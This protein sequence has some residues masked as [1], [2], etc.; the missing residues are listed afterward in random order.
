MTSDHRQLQ[1]YPCRLGYPVRK[2]PLL[3]LVPVK[4]PGLGH[5]TLSEPVTE[6]SERIGWDTPSTLETGR[7]AGG[8]SFTPAIRPKTWGAQGGLVARRPAGPHARDL[9][10]PAVHLG[11]CAQ[12]LPVRHPEEVAAVHE[13][14]EHHP[15]SLRR[16]LQ[17]HL[18]G[19]L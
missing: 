18:P 16:A 10:P 8:V 5:M 7:W 19:N 1:A 15:E 17:G 14:Q 11:F 4:V 3:L 12:L 13:H 9:S 2:E 6:G